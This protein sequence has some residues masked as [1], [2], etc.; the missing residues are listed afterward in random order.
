MF[1]QVASFGT[2]QQLEVAMCDEPARTQERGIK[3]GEFTVQ[4]AHHVQAERITEHAVRQI[5]ECR[6]L[7]A[8]IIAA[9]E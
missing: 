8:V 2:V 4:C 5:E 1:G 9:A 3:V 6:D 7:L